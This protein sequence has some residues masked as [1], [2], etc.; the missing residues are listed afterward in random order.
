MGE[1]GCGKSRLLAEFRDRATAEG[2]L[3]AVGSAERQTSLPYEPFAEM[4]R[5][6][7]DVIGAA[8]LDRVGISAPDLAWL[9]PE[10]VPSLR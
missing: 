4:I 5:M 8:T 1:A 7:I 2:V 10:S 6:I 3:V 9:L